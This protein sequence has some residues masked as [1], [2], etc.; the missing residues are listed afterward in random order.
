MTRINLVEPEELYDQHLVAEYREIFMVGSSLQRS[1]KSKNFN[2]ANYGTDTF[3]LNKG[4]VS[5]FYDKGEYLAKRYAALIAEMKI[6]GMSPDPGRVF[7]RWQWPDH[8][9]NDWV[10]SEHD[11]NII[12]ER[13]LLRVSEKP[14]WYRK[15]ERNVDMSNSRYLFFVPDHMKRKHEELY[16]ELATLGKV[17]YDDDSGGA[18]MDD[19]SSD[20]V[21]YLRLKYTNFDEHIITVGDY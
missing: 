9:Y 3:T 12:R 15:S 17:K 4:H 20:D 18:Y 7:K 11:R 2:I 13:I 10:P 14:N 16:T 5:F 19:I 1:I 8:L 21:F 6:R